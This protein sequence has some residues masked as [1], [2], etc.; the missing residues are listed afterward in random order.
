MLLYF[1]V[2]VKLQVVRGFAGLLKLNKQDNPISHNERIRPAG[3]VTVN[4]I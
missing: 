3:E 1:T 4:D 2:P